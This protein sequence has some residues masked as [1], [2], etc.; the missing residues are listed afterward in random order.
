MD[1]LAAYVW[2]LESDDER[3][4][5]RR[6]VEELAATDLPAGFAQ[7]LERLDRLASRQPA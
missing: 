4:S 2:S 6:L 7:V 3:A 5:R 1:Q